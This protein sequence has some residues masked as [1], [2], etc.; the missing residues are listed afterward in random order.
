MRVRKT[1]RDIQTESDKLDIESNER[2]RGE[3]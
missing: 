1:V 2:N 3:L